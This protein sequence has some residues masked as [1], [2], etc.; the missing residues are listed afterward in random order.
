MHDYD[1]ISMESDF[2]NYESE[3]ADETGPYGEIYGE[4]PFNEADELELASELLN[5]SNEREL[6]QFIGTLIKKAGEAAGKFIKSPVGHALGGIVKGAAKSALPMLGGVVGNMVLPGIGGAI[7]SKLASSA[8]SM[9]GLELEGLSQEDQEFEAARQIVRFAGAAASKAAD[10][11]HRTTPQ[12]AA[13]AAATSA[14]QQHAPGLLR[15]NNSRSAGAKAQCAHKD[16]GKW[17]R[18]GNTIILLEA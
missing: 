5:V 4:T 14:A 9:L 18:K 7:G 2:G 17:I 8:G 6:D 10:A 11:Q 15:N 1:R 13:Q 16:S 12:Q 3:F